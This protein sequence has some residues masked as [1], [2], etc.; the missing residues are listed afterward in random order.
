MKSIG[1][2][3]RLFLALCAASLP[4]LF[5]SLAGDAQA[6]KPKSQQVAAVDSPAT[7]QWYRETGIDPVTKWPIIAPLANGAVVKPDSPSGNVIFHVRGSDANGVFMLAMTNPDSDS[8]YV[9][10]SQGN[11][12]RLRLSW[13]ASDNA[14]SP[15]P[16][17]IRSTLIDRT[18]KSYS[19]QLS[20]N[21]KK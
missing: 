19:N 20:V 17:L 9:I 11:T 3:A 2:G 16:Y 12:I 4:C 10:P 15:P 21:L 18:G 1:F 6:H 5:L 7:F 14:D 13:K 8:G